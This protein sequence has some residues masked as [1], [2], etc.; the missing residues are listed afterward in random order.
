MKLLNNDHFLLV[1]DYQNEVV[2]LL[3]FP[4]LVWREQQAEQDLPSCNS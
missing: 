4:Y 2:P 3:T 1:K